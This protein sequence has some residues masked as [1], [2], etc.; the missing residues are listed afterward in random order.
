MK[1]GAAVDRH[2]LKLQ[3]PSLSKAIA[4]PSSRFRSTRRRLAALALPIALAWGVH[5]A[6]GENATA[7]DVPAT[8]AQAGFTAEARK[9][10][11]RGTIVAVDLDTRL[12]NELTGAVAMRVAIP[13]AAMASLIRGGVNVMA[14][15]E[16]DDFAPIPEGATER[17]LAALAYGEADRAE[18]LR[19]FTIEPGDAFNLSST[20]IATL[21]ER[22]SGRPDDDPG[23]IAAASAAWRTILLE[24]WRGYRERG[25]GG[26][27][28]YDR[29]TS[30]SWPGNELHRIDAGRQVPL[31]LR[32]FARAIDDFPAVPASIESLFFWKKTKVDDRPAFVMSHILL[33]ERPDAVFFAL[34]EFYATHS[35][36][37][38]EQL[39]IVLPLGTGSVMIA[40]NSTTTDRILGV[41]SALARPIGQQR[42]RAALEAYFAG[43]RD[44]SRSLHAG[45]R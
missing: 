37:A 32:A 29:G 15:P 17:S 9:K 44:L 25:L 41:F 23:A 33:E 43:I 6:H 4:V 2:H 12:D 5:P 30:V 31:S 16:L 7:L 13:M 22:L 14:D 38:L 28:G 39:G 36:N 11:E 18:A 19:L 8:F 27:A 1:V 26:L 24:R 20:E 10:V 45:D 35:Y 40:V 42:S 21:R 34:R 3:G